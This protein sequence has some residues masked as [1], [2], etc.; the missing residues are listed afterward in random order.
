MF[1]FHV[2]HFRNYFIFYLLFLLLVNRKL[3]IVELFLLGGSGCLY[4]TSTKH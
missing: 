4:R 2:R 1:P 3:G